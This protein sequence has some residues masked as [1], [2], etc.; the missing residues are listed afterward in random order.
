MKCTKCGTTAG[1]PGESWTMPDK[2]TCL[3]AECAKAYLRKNAEMANRRAMSAELESEAFN[4]D[5]SNRN[6]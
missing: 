6:T 2:W 5:A 3:C 4:R 1:T